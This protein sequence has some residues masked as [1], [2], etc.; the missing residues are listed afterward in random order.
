[1]NAITIKP[2]I[3]KFAIEFDNG[4]GITIETKKYS[5]S[6]GGHMHVESMASV[7]AETVKEILEGA[8]PIKDGWD[9]NEIEDGV[10]CDHSESSTTYSLSELIEILN[11]GEIP[12][13]V[14]YS[15]REFWKALGLTE[16]QD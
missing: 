15:E 8:N 12:E 14:G 5:L 16:S 9:G 7:A 6:F 11:S 13:R 2:T 3:R 10:R 4:G 1:M